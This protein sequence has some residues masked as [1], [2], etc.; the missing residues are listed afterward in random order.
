L[1]DLNEIDL[2]AGVVEIH[3]LRATNDAMTDSSRDTPDVII[4]PPLIPLSVLV[5]GVVLN[6]FIPL[7]LLAHVLF[8]GRIVVGVIAFVVGIGLVI[9][10]NRIFRR[11]GTNA[12]PSQPTLALATTSMFTRTRNPMYVGGSLVLLGVAIGFALDWVLLLLVVSLLL[13]HYGIILR[14][15][16]YLER[17]F[18]ERIPALQDEGPTVL[19]AILRLDT[20]LD[21]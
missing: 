8:L 1:P 16:R 4:F 21:R 13:V 15:E 10:A 7:G 14:E 17:K 5:V 11:I 19:V 20:Q 2:G 3:T 6:F 18:G 9:G 12:R